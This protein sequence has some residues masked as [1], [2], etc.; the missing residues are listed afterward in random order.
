VGVNGKQ[1]AN[2]HPC[3]ASC[4]SRCAPYQDRAAV[5]KR[6]I[7]TFD[8]AGATITLLTDAML[9]GW[10][11]LTVRQVPIGVNDPTPPSGGHS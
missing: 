7:N 5:A 9:P 11:E 8:R 1:Q 3:H 10:K 6:V 2:V 4:Q